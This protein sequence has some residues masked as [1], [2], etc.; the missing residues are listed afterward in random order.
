MTSTAQNV[1]VTDPITGGLDLISEEITDISIERR[2]YQRFEVELDDG[3][4]SFSATTSGGT[5]N[6]ALYIRPATGPAACKSRTAGNGESCSVS[7]PV[8]GI[9]YIDIVSGATST[10]VTLEYTATP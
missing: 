1:E 2:S 8:G 9:W 6:V 10:G 4:S 5:G 3:Y 7:N